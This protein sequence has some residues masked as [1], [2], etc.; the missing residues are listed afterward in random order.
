MLAV[1]DD[2]MSGLSNCAATTAAEN[3]EASLGLD[4]LRASVFMS[5]VQCCL[6]AV[7]CAA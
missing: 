6:S 1:N 5:G 2:G 7:A 4:A 3:G